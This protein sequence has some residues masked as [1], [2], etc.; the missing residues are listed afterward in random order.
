MIVGRAGI[1]I[2]DLGVDLLRRPIG[3]GDLGGDGLG[4]R[5]G[6][7]VDDLEGLRV[8]GSPAVPS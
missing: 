6:R 3:L 1:G 2:V 8:A 4:R 5:V 7:Q